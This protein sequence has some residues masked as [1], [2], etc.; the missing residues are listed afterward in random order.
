M[1]WTKEEAVRKTM[2]L[3]RQNGIE[4]PHDDIQKF[5]TLGYTQ[6][7]GFN[8]KV[9]NVLNDNDFRVR[10]CSEWFKGSSDEKPRI[11]TSSVGF[12]YQLLPTTKN[13]FAIY[14]L[15]LRDYARQLELDQGEWS[16]KPNWGMV[17]S[18]ESGVFTW[19]GGNTL[20][21]P[22]LVLSSPLDLGL[23]AKQYHAQNQHFCGKNHLG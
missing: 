10:V 11:R 5:L 14:Y 12:D 16:Q 13:L 21:F 4:L 9:A 3:L 22:L 17:V 6:I 2:Q 18:E 1:A 8:C 20:E 23:R 15:P 19:K 7:F